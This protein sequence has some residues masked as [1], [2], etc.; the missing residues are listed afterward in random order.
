MSLW[1]F[2]SLLSKMMAMTM[3]PSISFHEGASRKGGGII[4]GTSA[5][6]A[7]G[8]IPPKKPTVTFLEEGAG[9]VWLEPVPCQPPEQEIVQLQS[10]YE[11]GDGDHHASRSVAWVIQARLRRTMRGATACRRPAED[12]EVLSC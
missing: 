12:C 9:L 8:A 11:E 3:K 6:I 5:W 10:N 2:H 4:G 1:I 7:R